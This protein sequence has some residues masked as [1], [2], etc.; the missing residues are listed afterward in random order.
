MS[1][2]VESVAKC[3]FVSEGL[4]IGDKYGCRDLDLLKSLHIRTVINCTVT[5]KAGGLRNYYESDFQ[6]LRVPVKDSD[7]ENLT[8]F[9]GIACELIDR[10]LQ[11][12]CNVLVHCQQGKSR[13]ATI[14]LAY[15]LYKGSNLK[16]A[17]VKLKTARSIVK[18]KTAFLQQLVKWDKKMN[19]Q[20]ETSPI[21]SRKRQHNFPVLPSGKRKKLSLKSEPS[22]EDV[23]DDS[24][25]NAPTLLVGPTL[26]PHQ[27]SDSAPHLD[28]PKDGEVAEVCFP[29]HIR[30]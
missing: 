3:S 14:V 12:N 2:A 11:E 8:P 18:P 25:L 16:D 10:S 26:P 5:P 4:F 15:L 6:Y 7:L 22:R 19:T 21:A 27:V 17:Y 23:T 30:P 9:F 13:S 29:S 28:Q 20:K 24:P 1:V